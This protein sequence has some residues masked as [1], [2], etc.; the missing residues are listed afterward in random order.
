MGWSVVLALKVSLSYIDLQSSRTERE[1]ER[2]RA[3]SWF[4]IETFP[5]C[6]LLF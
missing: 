1:R 3:I 5:G 6:I 2:K 4:V